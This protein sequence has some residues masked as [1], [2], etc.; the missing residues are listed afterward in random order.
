M[1]PRRPD[2]ITITYAEHRADPQRYSRLVSTGVVV[3]LTKDGV[4]RIRPLCQSG[5]TTCD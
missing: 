2:P 3:T 5:L 1:Q 4:A